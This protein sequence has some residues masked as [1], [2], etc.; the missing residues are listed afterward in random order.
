MTGLVLASKSA[1]RAAVLRGAGVT[2][3][4]VGSGVN[5]DALKEELLAH[6]QTPARI[7]TA[8]AEAKALAVAWERDGLVIGCDQTLELDGK[9]FDKADSLEEA[10]ERLRALRGR[11]HELHSAVAVVRG[12]D[13]RFRE[14]DSAR[15]SMREFSDEWLDGYLAR[16][17]EAVLGS[18]GCY[19]LEGE[20]AQLFDH[21]VGDF[22]TIL[23]LPL[24]GLLDF[25]REEKVLGT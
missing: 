21:V 14:L 7:A 3:E 23:G 10:R 13:V 4:A 1:A 5:E 20:G 8:L 12:N 25:L 11:T 22:F 15:M 6:S 24:F 16:Q 9:L 17:G 19:Q 2:F 18:V